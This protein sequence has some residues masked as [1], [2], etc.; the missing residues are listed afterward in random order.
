MNNSATKHYA[1]CFCGS[2]SFALTGEPELMAYCHCDS[3]RHWSAGP[4]SEFS[5]W[6]PDSLEIL[7][8]E[9]KLASYDK[10]SSQSGGEILSER[11]WCSCCGG[12]LFT[13]HP[14]MG[15]IDVSRVIIEGL[16]FRP[17]FHVHYQET[18]LP[19]NDDLPKY[20]DLPAAAGGSGVILQGNSVH[21]MSGKPSHVTGAH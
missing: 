10:N 2:V 21:H 20:R 3:C 14:Q 7:T 1:R 12:H 4:V 17:A 5:L 19:I 11:V 13:R 6:Q 8:G 15:L 16:D 18:V 9:D